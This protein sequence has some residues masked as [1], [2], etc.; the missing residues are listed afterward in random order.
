MPR[1]LICPRRIYHSLES[2][3]L[4][5][6]RAV[7]GKTTSLIISTGLE[8]S[9]ALETTATVPLI[10]SRSGPNFSVMGLPASQHGLHIHNLDHKLNN[11]KI[12]AT[13][14]PDSAT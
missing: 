3:H 11:R 8:I 4:S 7:V 1:S 9:I 2:L 10:V 5:D 12:Q 14:Q 6:V 13:L